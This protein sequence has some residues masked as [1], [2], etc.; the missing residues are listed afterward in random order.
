VIAKKG[1]KNV[2]QV[3]PNQREWITVLASINANGES[4]PNF[5][6]FKGKKKSRIFLKKTGEKE[7]Y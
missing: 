7:L 2:H 4:I 5:C 6:I 1:S 3:T